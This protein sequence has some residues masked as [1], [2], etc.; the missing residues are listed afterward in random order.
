MHIRRARASRDAGF[1]LV[2]MLVVIVVIAILAGI[3]VPLFLGQR[4]KAHDAA[5]KADLRTLSQA[6]HWELLAANEDF[7]TVHTM[8]IEVEEAADGSRRY[9]MSGLIRSE[10]WRS[11]VAHERPPVD[12]GPVSEGI[13]LQTYGGEEWWGLLRGMADYED[14]GP[15]G[16]DDIHLANFCIGVSHVEGRGAD[17]RYIAHEGFVPGR[18][19]EDDWWH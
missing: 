18:C 14:E 4:A 2:E 15:Q 17:W 9:V 19:Y 8:Q 1:T 3:A 16:R 6:I 11:V 12:L 5:A 10:T 13:V 7:H